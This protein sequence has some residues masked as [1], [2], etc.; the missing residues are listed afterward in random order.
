MS[1]ASR[2]I[3]LRSQAFFCSARWL[4]WKTPLFLGIVI[5]SNL[6]GDVCFRLGLRQAGHLLL[7][8]R[9]VYVEAILTPWIGFGLI[10]YLTW[11]LSQT[12]LFSWA[13]LSYVLP[14]TSFG[15]A[16]AALAGRLLLDELI[17]PS[18]WLGVFFITLGILLVSL[19]PARSTLGKNG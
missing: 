17:S 2:E 10:F 15:Y 5:F 3:P 19:T 7:E 14:M 11:L 8:L 13:D 9:G 16:L 6:A 18:R 4:Q 1:E 12:L